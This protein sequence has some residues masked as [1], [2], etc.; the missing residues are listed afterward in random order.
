MGSLVDVAP[1][2]VYGVLWIEPKTS[3]LI[4]KHQHPQPHCPYLKVG[5]LVALLLSAAF[6]PFSHITEHVLRTPLECL[7]EGVLWV[8]G[9]DC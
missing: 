4:G 2:L 5:Y 9:R 1:H 8:V 3:C 6:N 7:G